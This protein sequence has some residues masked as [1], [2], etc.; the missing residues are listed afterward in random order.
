MSVAQTV[1]RLHL[2][3]ILAALIPG[4]VL[5]TIFSVVFTGDFFDVLVGNAGVFLVFSY[6]FGNGIQEGMTLVANAPQHF[7]I[8]M[9]DVVSENSRNPDIAVT[10]IEEGFL[11]LCLDEFELRDDFDDYDRLFDMLLSYLD[12]KPASRGLRFQALF[13]FYWAMEFVSYLAV[14]VGTL[15][16]VASHVRPA[17]TIGQLQILTVIL[18]SVMGIFVFRARRASFGEDFVEYVIADFYNYKITSG[19]G[20]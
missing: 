13:S 14:L 1:G 3:D 10:E 6:V 2:F 7:E 18:F 16:L 9:E 12:T 4:A 20:G 8:L 15:A 11:D 19:D 17:M 5:L